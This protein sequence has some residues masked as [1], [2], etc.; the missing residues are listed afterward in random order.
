MEPNL[1]RLV[2]K[3]GVNDTF[4][5]YD[6]ARFNVAG[7]LYFPF[8]KRRLC[9]NKA[10][11]HTVALYWMTLRIENVELILKCTV[12]LYIPNITNTKTLREVCFRWFGC[13]ESS[14]RNATTFRYK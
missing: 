3:A 13:R 4:A 5:R 14:L 7:N 12:L 8:R 1:Q 2:N 10:T 9:R 11:W 6:G